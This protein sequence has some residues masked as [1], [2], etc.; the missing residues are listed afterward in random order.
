[1]FKK[2]EQSNQNMIIIIVLVLAFV[3]FTMIGSFIYFD[4]VN[5]RNIHWKNQ[6]QQPQEKQQEEDRE[7]PEERPIKIK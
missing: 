7:N 5:P 1:M 3:I 2:I 4:T 6:Q